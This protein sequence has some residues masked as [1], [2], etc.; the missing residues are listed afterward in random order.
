MIL[1]QQLELKEKDGAIAALERQIQEKERVNLEAQAA[2]ASSRASRVEGAAAQGISSETQLQEANRTI[3]RHL[4]FIDRLI[5][6]KKV[7]SEQC[8]ALVGQVKESDGKFAKHLDEMKD[9]HKAELRKRKDAALTAEKQRREKWIREKTQQIKDMT[10][11][12]LEPQIERMI[13]E[14]KAEITRVREARPSTADDL[15]VLTATHLGALATQAA[16]HHRE[17]AAAVAA[18]RETAARDAEARAVT[19]EREFQIERRRLLDGHEA[20]K[21]ECQVEIDRARDEA[22][23]EYTALRRADEGAH[24]ALKQDTERLLRE[25]SKRHEREVVA[26]KEQLAIEKESWED[27]YMRKQTAQ[28]KSKEADIREELRVERDRQINMV[29]ERLEKENCRRV[30][31]NDQQYETRVRRIREQYQAQLHDSEQAEKA[32]LTKYNESRQKCVAAN[33]EVASLRG[34]L[35]QRDQDLARA[36]EVG[37]RLSSERDRVTDIV[38]SE[39]SEKL[40]SREAEVERARTELQTIKD[41]SYREVTEL[42]NAKDLEFDRL[43]ARVEAAVAKKD[44]TI[45]LLREKADA[46]ARRAD[47][48]EELFETQRQHLGK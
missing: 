8:E 44:E 39:F 29:I 31:E 38:R 25:C 2:Q 32:C 4:K 27:M 10:V 17:M 46:A 40:A 5:Q 20:V 11:K 41:K 43:H 34:M 36:T 1:S 30:E 9:A 42:R 13:Q 24:I 22:K 16:E 21:V 26:L 37:N 33:E 14:H 15:E 6:D 45:A 48:L 35:V 23:Q 28:L 12:G 47:H 18:V 7:L 3:N 19:S